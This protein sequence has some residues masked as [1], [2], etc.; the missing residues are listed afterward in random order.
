VRGPVKLRL[1]PVAATDDA[2]PIGA[3]AL[4]LLAT[5]VLFL[6]DARRVVYANP[7]A[8]NL[9]ELSRRKFAGHTPAELFAACPALTAAIDKAI[10]GGASYTEQ[11][12]ELAPPGRAKLHLACTVSPVDAGEAALLL[13]FRHIDQQLKI[14]REER[15]REQQQA[16][17]ELIRSLAHEIKNPLGGIRGAAQLLEGELDRPALV[18]YT[19]VI[20]AEADRL[21]ALVNRL[22]APHRTPA[23]RPSNV[24]EVLVRVKGVVQAEFPVIPIVCDF[25]SSLP[26]VEADYEQLMQAALNIVRNAAQA[27]SGSP[28]AAP[29]IRLVTRIARGVTLA[30]RRHRLAIAIAIEDNG[31]G[32][33]EGIRDRIFF[34][35][36]S[37]REGGSGLGLTIAQTLIAQ[38]GGTIE[39]TSAPGHTA[40]TVLLP[41]VT[42]R[43]SEGSAS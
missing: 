43:A 28:V 20:I 31:P 21:R 13:E 30:Q 8:E 34:P 18:E 41:L 6:D 22:L 27:L 39:C 19:Q 36:V 4:D 17:R 40:F 3:R 5:A 16:N 37:G 2:P 10:A 11:E 12:L 9:F 25:D 42:A 33:P 32:V 26:D 14:A 15:L 1:L 38:H 24:H 29:S 35:L 7:A 23:Y